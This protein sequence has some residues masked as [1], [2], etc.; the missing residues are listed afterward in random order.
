MDSGPSQRRQA[1]VLSPGPSA[2]CRL[3]RMG[4]ATCAAVRIIAVPTATLR[5]LLGIVQNMTTLRSTWRRFVMP[6]DWAWSHRSGVRISATP[7]GLTRFRSRG[8]L[9]CFWAQRPVRPCGDIWRCPS[10][11]APP[12]GTS[13]ASPPLLVGCADASCSS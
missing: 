6:V 4:S 9:S 1:H 11:A 10:A 12:F 8:M 5:Y 3:E 2:W 7:I 13:T